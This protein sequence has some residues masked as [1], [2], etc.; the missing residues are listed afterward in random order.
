M[1]NGRSIWRTIHW[2]VKMIGP[3]TRT[4]TISGAERARATSSARLMAMVLGRTSANTRT[5]TVIT[6]VATAMPR[7]PG[8]DLAMNSVVRAE[9]RM[10]I[11]L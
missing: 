11:R 3:N 4:V 1:P 9:V 10:L 6:A 7:A 2:M 8:I 5:R